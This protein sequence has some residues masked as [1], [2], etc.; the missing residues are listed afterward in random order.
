[1]ERRNH[2]QKRLTVTLAHV[3]ISLLIAKTQVYC[4]IKAHWANTAV[5]QHK[6]LLLL[7]FSLFRRYSSLLMTLCL[8]LT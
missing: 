6:Q 7:D 1:M 4:S 2:L 3:N 5:R 8:K